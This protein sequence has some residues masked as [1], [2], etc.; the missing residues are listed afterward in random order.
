M[1]AWRA[2]AELALGVSSVQVL[3]RKTVVI[4]GSASE[5]GERLLN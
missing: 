4:V 5:L 3:G 2:L 1:L